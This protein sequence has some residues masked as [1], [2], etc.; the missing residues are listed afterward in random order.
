MTRLRICTVLAALVAGLW[1]QPALAWGPQGH[2]IIIR[3]AYG[4]LTAPQRAKFDAIVAKGG[5][6]KV[7]YVD[8][9]GKS[10]RCSANSLGGL[11]NWA[12]CVRYGGPYKATYNA[13]FDDMPYCPKPPAPAP[14][15]ASYC[16]DGICA[17]AAIPRYIALLKAPGT[18]D[19][20]RAAALAFIIHFVGDAHQPLHNI[21]NANDHGGN[22]VVV[23][24]APIKP[25]GQSRR[26]KLHKVW[27]GD[28]IKWVFSSEEVGVKATAARAE[29]L[30]ARWT[31]NDFGEA[32][33]ARWSLA[34][35]KLAVKAYDAVSPAPA[36]GVTDGTVHKIDQAYFGK[37]NLDV[38]DQL[39]A[40]SVRLADILE[41]A[42]AATP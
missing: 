13:H 28:V 5:T 27:D 32:A 23:D 31:S 26:T 14:A 22:S 17:S 42:L 41:D 25:D 10:Q 18:T 36:C 11:A 29:A 34:T 40:A 33:T 37:F 9:E 7:E 16:Q 3:V 6:L 4:R 38:Q 30:H 35:H 15:K 1:F 39:A 8:D 21:D 2:D 12:D 19:F 24:I 20:E